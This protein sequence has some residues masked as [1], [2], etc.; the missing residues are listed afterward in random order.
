MEVAV[1]VVARVVVWVA[2]LVVVVAT[3]SVSGQNFR[4]KASTSGEAVESR[5]GEKGA[6]VGV[7]L[8]TTAAA[9][10]IEGVGELIVM[11]TGFD[12]ASR[13]T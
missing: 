9:L 6:R 7:G 3:S 5:L 13:A 4:Y 12:S 1:I 10:A 2:V 8:E 11:D